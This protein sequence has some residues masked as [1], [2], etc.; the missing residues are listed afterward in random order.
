MSR[1]RYHLRQS[2]RAF[3]TRREHLAHY[4][5]LGDCYLLCFDVKK[6]AAIRKTDVN[7]ESYGYFLVSSFL[8]NYVYLAACKTCL[9]F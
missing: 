1:D 7:M 5:V 2:S 9:E 6:I 4:F 8:S 3:N